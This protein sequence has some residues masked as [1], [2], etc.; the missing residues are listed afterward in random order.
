[1]APRLPR[2]R[3]A[4]LG[5]DIATPHFERL[6]ERRVLDASFAV[7]NDSLSL[8]GWD[9]EVL[10]ISEDTGADT[11]QLHLSNGVWNGSDAPGLTGNGLSTLTVDK[12]L[13]NGLPNG[14]LGWEALGPATFRTVFETVDFSGMSGPVA[15][16]G[17][18]TTQVSGSTVVIPQAFFRGDVFL[19]E[20]T[21]DFDVIAVGIGQHA[22]ADIDDIELREVVN[23]FD[24]SIVA[25]GTISTSAT[26]R[27]F[28]SG[29]GP[30]DLGH[31]RL[32]SDTGIDFSE[33]NMF[34]VDE[35]T[36]NTPGDA[37]F[38]ITNNA[39]NPAIT[40]LKGSNSA[41]NL[42]LNWS[43]GRIHDRGAELIVTEHA[44]LVATEIQ[45]GNDANSVLEVG[46][47][48]TLESEFDAT[49]AASI[50]TGQGQVAVGYLNFNLERLTFQQP[51]DI[52]LVGNGI[53]DPTDPLNFASANLAET[54]QLISAGLITDG[55][56][57]QTQVNEHALFE[58]AA[59]IDVVNELDDQLF[60][61]GVATF[62]S[63]GDMNIGW[64]GFGHGSNL[65]T[66]FGYLNLNGSP[67][68]E[69]LIQEDEQT[70]FVGNDFVDSSDPLDF[71]TANT[72]GSLRL[73]TGGS[74]TDYDDTAML[75]DE[76]HM[77]NNAEVVLAD[78]PNGNSAI[79]DLIDLWQVNSLFVG[80]RGGTLGVDGAPLGEGANVQL[81]EF[82][83]N[84]NL[85]PVEV[86]IDSAVE[87]TSVNTD[88]QSRILA[89][90]ISGMDRMTVTGGDTMTLESLTGI[91]LQPI[92]MRVDGTLN[93]IAPDFINL[94]NISRSLRI[95]NLNFQS[96]GNVHIVN[97]EG[98]SVTPSDIN[99]TGANRANDL[100][101]ESNAALRDTQGTTIDV[102]GHAVF[103]AVGGISLGSFA[104]ATSD[105]N[106]A[107]SAR[108]EAGDNIFAK[109]NFTRLSFD[110]PGV[111]TIVEL[112]AT[113]LFGDNGAGDLSITS[114]DAISDSPGTVLSVADSLTMDAR[115]IFVADRDTDV[116]EAGGETRVSAT[117]FMV[118][119]TAG[120]VD[121]GRLNFTSPGY[122]Q[123]AEDSSTL[124]V[125]DNTADAAF[126]TS[127]GNIEDYLTT[128]VEVVGNLTLVAEN[129]FVADA[130]SNVWRAGGRA[131]LH[132]VQMI[133]AGTPD[134]LFNPDAATLEF[135]QLNFT[136]SGYVTVNETDG[137][138]L[139]GNNR[140]DRFDLRSR[141]YLLN[142]S[143][144]SVRADTIAAFY[145]PVGIA[146]GL[147]ASDVIEV[148]E[149]AYF[150]SD[151]WVLVDEPADVTIVEWFSDAPN[152]DVKVDS[153]VC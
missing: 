71:A 81:V 102:L 65:N 8:N 134:I 150:L 148:C 107:R 121:F 145:S 5:D 151:V 152:L 29:L 143:G 11:Y 126:L 46:G 22:I 128:T 30:S 69:M 122:V 96:D 51:G 147:N 45:L 115:V 132:A 84:D 138:Y 78:D 94:G 118:F 116:I 109:G 58:G 112:S 23:V 75:F 60:V 68:S 19:E 131:E 87:L 59:G 43:W 39:N 35:L 93:L 47:V 44:R 101:L 61:D 16:Y 20:S 49:G 85:I 41:G 124:L 74:I 67:T 119:G 52:V 89:Q 141:G 110:S 98:P 88:H 92:L 31:L 95:T 86:R 130:R 64:D 27:V 38:V 97:R 80:T 117:D 55:A 72:G 63:D 4:R 1:M 73:N 3:N 9:P 136:A 153:N 144:M 2:R 13:L 146:L 36:F 33:L 149:T 127:A 42:D 40:W 82:G 56:S 21:N 12:S 90:D 104:G 129:I 135:G 123:I 6:E 14:L 137:M 48:L 25:G 120:T 53:D 57:A 105:F 100:I 125:L 106:V 139:V 62:R 111:V 54:L 7:F 26:S 133:I 28:V 83:I 24:M 18:E 103:K 37:K 77:I 17:L 142:A 140:S 70:E 66:N 99:L 34:A 50:G 79:S 15:L 113:R 114:T 32:T 76:I 91:D 10:T 108:F